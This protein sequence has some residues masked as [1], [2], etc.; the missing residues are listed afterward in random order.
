MAGIRETVKSDQAL[1]NI[2][3]VAEILEL[4]QHVLRFWETKF[5][6]LQP[7]KRQGGRRFYRPVDVELLKAIKVLLHD[8]GYTIKGAV[9]FLGKNGARPQGDLFTPSA[10]PVKAAPAKPA[11]ASPSRASIE[12]LRKELVGIKEL[13]R[14]AS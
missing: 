10:E 8:K 13:L 3:E 12:E 5:P 1:K 4:P 2:R 6:Q 9:A 7:L 11:A 14:Q